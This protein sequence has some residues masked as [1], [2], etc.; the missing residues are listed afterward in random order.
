MGKA[1]MRTQ[2]WCFEFF[3]I[4]Y[5]VYPRKLVQNIEKLKVQKLY[6]SSRPFKWYQECPI[7][8]VGEKVIIKIVKDFFSHMGMSI[9]T[10]K[11]KVMITKSQRSLIIISYMI[12]KK[13]KKKMSSYNYLIINL[14]HSIN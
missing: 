1:S 10:I 6:L 12:I 3:D 2:L 4:P 5:N 8:S 14:Q 9:N 11:T 13:I 7:P